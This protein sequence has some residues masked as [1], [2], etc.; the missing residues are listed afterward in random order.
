MTE[1]V[2]LQGG[3]PNPKLFEELK[4]SLKKI[5]GENC[6]ER[7]SKEVTRKG[8][9]TTG[10][11]YQF[12][13]NR[14]N[15]ILPKYGLHWSTQDEI[16]LLKEY[17]SKSGQI[18]YEY[19]GRLSLLFLNDFREVVDARHCYGGHQSSTHADAMKGAFTNAFKK[20]AA[21]FGVGADA[22]EGAI[23]EDY[24]PV[25]EPAI[26]PITNANIAIQLTGAEIKEIEKEI[27]AIAGVTNKDEANS[28]SAMITATVGK[29]TGKQVA[30]LRRLLDN[31]VKGL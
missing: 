20:T 15:E 18:Y 13:V 19:A 3:K 9:D 12:V 25:E 7:T 8:Y 24:R 6:V 28:V 2:E 17:P 21:L 30:Y 1:K 14:L 31:K 11:G 22:Y 23:D 5:Y 27:T 29:V 16:K 26:D 10:Y 4:E